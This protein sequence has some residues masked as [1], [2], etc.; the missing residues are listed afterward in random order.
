MY[1]VIA[2]QLCKVEQVDKA[3][4]ESKIFNAGMQIE[5]LNRQL[6][7][8]AKQKEDILYSI[9]DLQEVIKQIYPNEAKKM[10]LL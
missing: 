1:K 6:G 10:G 2:G 3:Q 8:L 7:V 4:V 5:N 9:Q